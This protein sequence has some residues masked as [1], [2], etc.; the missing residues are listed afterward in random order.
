MIL[1]LLIILA[2]I[3]MKKLVVTNDYWDIIFELTS[4]IGSAILIMAILGILIETEHWSKYFEARLSKVVVSRDFFKLLDPHVLIAI[5]KQVLQNYFNNDTLGSNDDFFSHYENNIQ[6]LMNT[7]FRSNLTF[8][9]VIDYKTGDKSRLFIIETLSWTCESVGNKIQDHVKWEPEKDECESVDDYEVIFE[10][11]KIASGSIKREKE[12]LQEHSAL[13]ANSM[14]FNLLIPEYETFNKLKINLTVKYV[15]PLPKF[16][17]WVL[18]HP[19]KGIT[20]DI[21][22]PKDLE[23]F[24]EQ[25]FSNECIPVNS[26]GK[27][28][29]QSD[30]WFLP[31]EGIAFQLYKKQI[32]PAVK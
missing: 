8:K 26:E 22:Y 32:S 29:L 11:E 16:I 24:S 23:I 13:P 10:H 6:R 19:I 1:G 7:P 4:H 27:Y 3:I 2:P 15:I 18:S 14:G 31:N 20:I 17:A 12:Y 21:D 30:K 5:Q 9:L 25:F 28:T